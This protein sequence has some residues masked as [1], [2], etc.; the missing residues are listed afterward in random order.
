MV[1]RCCVDGVYAVICG[2][3]PDSARFD[4]KGLGLVEVDMQWRGLSFSEYCLRKLIIKYL[5][6]LF[7]CLGRLVSAYIRR[8]HEDRRIQLGRRLQEL[9]DER[10]IE[11]NMRAAEWIW[12][13]G[14][15]L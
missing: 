4:H 14:F 9:E 8:A 6:M 12:E 11:E 13:S 10:A 2:R 3:S 7:A 1:R 5:R 15:F